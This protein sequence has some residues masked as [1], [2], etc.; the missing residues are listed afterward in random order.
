MG[1][2]NG[3]ADLEWRTAV[4]GRPSGRG[5]D[6]RLLELQCINRSVDLLARHDPGV[7]PPRSR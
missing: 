6:R 4:G 5:R 1:W 3:G 2:A 7:R